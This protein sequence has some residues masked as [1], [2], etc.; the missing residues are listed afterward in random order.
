MLL[1]SSRLIRE[2]TR[3][4]R[5]ARYHVDRTTAARNAE[6]TAR[7]K[8]KIIAIILDRNNEGKKKKIFVALCLAKIIKKKK[9]RLGHDLTDRFFSPSLFSVSS[10]SRL[11]PLPSPAHRWFPN[12]NVFKSRYYIL[13]RLS[14]WCVTILQ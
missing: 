6:D 10:F 1:C 7:K 14:D 12:A 9:N 11:L 8:I 4:K 2:K 13:L 5:L 3:K